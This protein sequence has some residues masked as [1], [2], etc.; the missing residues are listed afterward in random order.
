VI[1]GHVIFAG[2]QAFAWDLVAERLLDLTD[3][4][5]TR[6]TASV[7]TSF[8]SYNFSIAIGLVLSFFLQEIARSKVQLAVLALIAITACIGFWGTGSNIILLGRLLP[9]LVAFLLLL[10]LVRR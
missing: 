6:K 7:G 1:V 3:L 9:A 2:M 10:A 8:A 4:D 5:T